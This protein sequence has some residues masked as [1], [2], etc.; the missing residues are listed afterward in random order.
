MPDRAF[1][2]NW[3]CV[4]V[5]R[6]DK[7]FGFLIIMIYHIY[8]ILGMKRNINCFGSTVLGERGQ[9][10]IPAEVRK[11]SGLKKG[12]RF[13]VFSDAD[14]LIFLLR[15]NSLKEI[16]SRLSKK[17]NELKKIKV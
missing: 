15:G 1:F 5:G 17:L 7:I 8:H 13:I 3:D 4:D 14:H 10:V 12:E 11:K 6:L 9:I 16:I 2:W